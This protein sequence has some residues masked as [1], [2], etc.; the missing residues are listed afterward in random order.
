MKK[1]TFFL[2]VWQLLCLSGYV[3]SQDFSFRATAE[4]SFNMPAKDGHQ[5]DK[6]V[7][8]T[9]SFYDSGG[10]SGNIR[11]GYTG[12]ICFVPANP[13]E[14]IE[15]TFEE[16]DLSGDASVQVYYGEVKSSGWKNKPDGYVADL[17]GQQTNLTYLS[18]SEDGKLSVNSYVT[19]S[20]SGSGWKAVV[21]SVVPADMSYAGTSAAVYGQEI[22]YPG[23][24]TLPVMAVNVQ[25]EGSANAFSVSQLSFNLDGTT[26]PA[27]LENIKVYYTSSPT[28]SADR[29]FGEVSG[30]VS[31][32]FI[33]SGDQKLRAGNNY[34]WLAGDVA[35]DA[36]PGNVLTAE[37]TTVTVDGV[38]QPCSPS[39]PQGD[40]I[41][42]Q[43]I[44]M[45][46][47]GQT[48]YAVGDDPITFY[49]DGGK[50]ASITVGFEGS[51]TFR[52]SH[53]GKK[54]QIDFTKVDLRLNTSI[55]NDDI[56]KVY[57][58][59]L[60]EEQAL[61]RII[62]QN[63]PV[64]IKSTAAD[65]S[66]TVTLKSVASLPGTGFEASVSEFTPV[67][68]AVSGIIPASY[69][70][71][72]V[73]AGDAGQPIL[74]VNIRTE[75]TE[76]ALTAQSF[77][78]T[79][80]GTTLLS[81]LTKAT[82]YYT[83]RSDAFAATTKVGETALTETAEF[84]ITGNQVLT[85][86]DNYFW[87]TYDLSQQAETGR[88][89]DAGCLSVNLLD[90]DVTV[91]HG[92][93]EGSRPVKNE[94]VSKME[95]ASRTIFSEWDYT[96]VCT[97]SLNN[98]DQT[99]T[100]VPGTAGYITELVFSEFR[101]Y[102]HPSVAPTFEIYS[103]TTTDAAK[104]LWKATTSDKTPVLNKAYR[105]LSGDSALTIR[106]NQ[107]GVQSSSS[108]GWKSKVRP[109]LSQPM[110]IEEVTVTQKNT[111]FISGGDTDQEI[112]GI[113]IKTAGDQHPLT[114]DGLNL[115][116]K[117]SQSLIHQVSL[118][119]T[120]ADSV[121]GVENPIG[122]L[123]IEPGSSAEITL[124]PTHQTYL[125]EGRSY[126]WIAYDMNETVAPDRPVDAS[127]ISYTASG[128]VYPVTNGDPE[129]AR[130]TKNIY[131][132]KTSGQE[133]LTIG[134]YSYLFYDDGGKD[135]KYSSK[136]S[137]GTV[138]F[139]PAEAGKVIKA[140]FLGFKNSTNDNLEFYSGQEVNDAGLLVK[141]DG[142]KTGNLPG[143][144]LSEAP[145][146]S[147][148]VR[149]NQQ[150]Y[151]VNDGWEIEV[152]ACTPVPL[153]AGE[154]TATPV[155]KDQLLG[156]A[157]DE[158]MLKIAV[159]VE[160]EQGELSV[161]QLT[162]A[163]EGT[164]DP[165]SLKETKL[166]YTGTS[167]VFA[168]ATPYSNGLQQSDTPLVFAG[169]TQITKPGIYY[170]W[171]TCDLSSDAVIGDVIRFT[172]TGITVNGD[173][174][175]SPVSE[176]AE[177][178]VKDGFHGTYT[179]GNGGQYKTFAQAIKMMEDGINGPVVFELESGTYDEAVYITEIIGASAENTV[180]FR[181]KSGNPED[182]ILTS[183]TYRTPGYNEDENGV[184]TLYGADY[185]I[186]DGV[187][188]TTAKAYPYLIDVKNASQHVTIRNCH[189]TRAVSSNKYWLI[190][191]GFV[192]QPI[193]NTPNTYL[194]VENCVLT[195][196]FTGIEIGGASTIDTNTGG[197]IRGNVFTD[198]WSKAIYGRYISDLTI[199]N[200]RISSQAGNSSEFDAI[201]IIYGYENTCIR[202]NRIALNLPYAVGIKSRPVSGTEEKPVR[203]YNNEI[204][205][206]GVTNASSRGISLSS[207][208]VA[209][210]IQYN[211]IR[212]SG[213]AER[214]TGI[215]S[216]V[217]KGSSVSI[218][219]NVVQ[220]LAGG[221]VFWVNSTSW[222]P[223]TVFGHNVLYST[224]ESLCRDQA[225]LE[226]WV[227]ASGAVGS[228][229]EQ[230]QFLSA[231]ILDLKVPGGLSIGEPTDY[232]TED[233]CGTV[234]SLTTP[235][236]GAY[237]YVAVTEAPALGGEYPGIRRVT[238]NSAVI[239]VKT[240]QHAE[241]YRLLR[242]DNV[243][244]AADEII[245]AGEKVQVLRNEEK[246]VPVTGLESQ[247]TYYPFLVLKSLANERLSE[248]IACD[249][250]MTT[251][252]QTE[253]ATFEQV[254][255]S[256]EAFEDGTARFTGFTV[257]SIQDGIPGSDKAAR[258]NGTGTVELTNTEKGLPINGF[259]VKSDAAI[260]LSVY[261]GT[262][263][264]GSKEVNATDGEWIFCNLRDMGELTSVTFSTSGDCLIDD[265]AGEP[266]LLQVQADDQSA[267]TGETVTVTP[268]PSGGVPPYTYEWKTWQGEAVTDVP[269][270]S[271][272]ATLSRPY[273]LTV[274]DAWAHSATDTVMIRVKGNAETATFDDLELVAESHWVGETHPNKVWMN[275]YSG[276][277]AFSTYYNQQWD[278]WE[279]FAYSNE[280]STEFQWLTDQFRSAVGSGVNGSENYGIAYASNYSGETAIEILN[281][282]EGDTL[283]GMFVSNS[284]WGY[285]FILNGDDSSNPFKK[286]D[287][288]KL[289]ATG[290]SADRTTTST[291]F[292]LADY[293]SDDR[294]EWY[295]LNSWE[296]M[297]LRPL[298][299]V[300]RI[301]FT[302]DG[303]RKD[304][305]GML[306][307]T[308]FCLDDVNG[309]LPIGTNRSESVRKGAS[310]T[311]AM[312]SWF[313]FTD[314]AASVV[315]K[316][317]SEPADTVAEASIDGDRLTVRGIEKGRTEWVVSA[318]QKGRTEFAKVILS[319]TDEVGL[320]SVTD[321][322]LSV[323]PV[324]ARHTLHIRTSLDVR[325]VEII[326]SYGVRVSTA[327]LT[328]GQR[329][330]DVSGL[331][332][333]SYILRL[334]TAEGTINRS[335]LKAEQ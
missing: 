148:T 323:Y 18:D 71:G 97:S 21:R 37:C 91:D 52:P 311:F 322:Q 45:M 122:S 48:R 236:A 103:G 282:P 72:T 230:A 197:T 207:K 4:E 155:N 181:S 73:A 297:D 206:N 105:P 10:P 64:V 58:G 331:V 62:S 116:L 41:T 75:N 260:R 138:T 65:G 59:S 267:E 314:A 208:S 94:Y 272:E 168:T 319:V 121:F 266:R 281:R 115:N 165:K 235:T 193:A 279:G 294:N 306:I 104:L 152:A 199:E 106:Y 295:A 131:L 124:V 262:E 60:A 164:F 170:Y 51:V 130:L 90:K 263:P 117:N 112:I 50:N 14:A 318:T 313:T 146:G 173:Q 161:D 302:M 296:W 32:D 177:V 149:F 228:I 3:Q 310:E 214:A 183:T 87:L 15:I 189:L 315:Y 13:G 330:I 100:F 83:S 191:T 211:T 225:T 196:G 135:G 329:S 312:D 194:T 321:M 316:L 39:V 222:A 61:N 215:Q 259:Y 242:T 140:T 113:C 44:V 57:N 224:S 269:V 275:F 160:G 19:Y 254:Q 332:P 241:I 153:T 202:N 167:S 54:V 326:S 82:L 289:T 7:D 142:D 195:G 187:T 273:I 204:N 30:S 143:P 1:I 251:F 27:D 92:N 42:I 84:V 299:K 190:H 151:S 77:R 78:F 68:M 26:R 70:E 184:F 111:D 28:F 213:A 248:V 136:T 127:L 303:S 74:S 56:L 328:G 274:T 38:A 35:A 200:N 198:Q 156:G 79:T 25:T 246:E 145:D 144:V 95:T 63:S 174:T 212:L 335:F 325:Y 320:T 240:D 118:Y 93:P 250:F 108:Y 49:D 334:Y 249:S 99:V 157:Q 203:I 265:F 308:Y 268:V 96:A 16:L 324:P 88:T 109:Y 86:G 128:T 256:G 20:G 22:A 305:W 232:V 278:S 283:S 221:P 40:P 69:T 8:G 53:P 176:T 107:N 29:L 9:L 47:P 276:S 210:D 11:T 172:N 216:A 293:R 245:A 162:F 175:V 185:V 307:P 304:G 12:S 46:S 123:E 23:K 301:V 163:L 134:D 288:F 133:T 126:Y 132:M 280:T 201:D 114:L 292:Y 119:Y 290:V 261:R 243:L 178:T 186:L 258:L 2:F 285:D 270:L 179:I 192:N 76:P 264:T 66:L 253:V 284:A 188:V 17:T 218:K 166:Y 271:L 234:R 277:Y 81:D 217:P 317:Y 67:E 120:D 33:V 333:G 247:T 129:G 209:V 298:G 137:L 150:G 327:D 171:L 220:N 141:Y 98:Q 237:E 227:V 291:D 223:N 101:L 89:I 36:V 231:S 244:P 110:K 169:H 147:L 239:V 85:E 159:T 55:N 80:E 43:N 287:W 5:G 182:V 6:V 300:T 219:N 226:E 252:R 238:E 309:M 255:A 205:L 257:E 229:E 180:T 34:F 233:I 31:A 24:K 139:K 125:Q 154:V 102:F 286:G 158:P